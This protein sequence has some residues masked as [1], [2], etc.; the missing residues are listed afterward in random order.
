[1]ARGKDHGLLLRGL[2]FRP[3]CAKKLSF[4]LSFL[5]A[6]CWAN[7]WSLSLEFWPLQQEEKGPL[8]VGFP[9]H[10]QCNVGLA[11]PFEEGQFV[12]SETKKDPGQ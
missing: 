7:L 4:G 10:V 8:R 9:L 1:M 11:L 12:E 5:S 3:F 2:L 6:D